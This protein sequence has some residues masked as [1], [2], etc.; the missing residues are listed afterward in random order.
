VYDFTD[1]VDD[2]PAGADAILEYCGVD[3]TEIFE[4]L[5]NRGMLDDFE[6]IGVKAW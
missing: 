3:G 5:H 1:F 4:E 6:P 2:H